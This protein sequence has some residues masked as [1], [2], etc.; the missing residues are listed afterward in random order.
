MP[1]IHLIELDAYHLASGHTHRWFLATKPGYRSGP[2]DTPKSLPWLP[3]VGKPSDV[4]LSIASLG[5]TMGATRVTLGSVELDN[6]RDWQGERQARVYDVTADAWITVTL[7]VRPLNPLLTDYALAGWPLTEKVIEE[8]APYSTAQVVASVT[9]EMPDPDSKRSTINLA[10][11]GREA[12]FDDP[13]LTDKYTTSDGESLADRTKERLFGHAFQE[14]TYLGIIGGL[15][16]WSHNGG[17]PIED[18]PV[19]WDRAFRLTKRTTGTPA[20]GEFKTDPATGITVTGSRPPEPMCEVKGDKT[21][22][23]WR[24]Y[25]GELAQHLAVTVGGKVPLARMDAVSV[26]TLDAVPREVGYAIPTGSSPTLREALDKLLGSLARGYWIVTAE[27]LLTVGRL[28]APAAPAARVYRRGINTPGLT[29]RNTNDRGLPAK[30]VTLRY[31]GLPK[32][33]QTIVT[34]AT[35]ADTQLHKALWRE[36]TDT[37]AATAAAYPGARSPT[38]ETLLWDRT[39]AV[40][41]Q[42]EF[43]AELKQVRRVYDLVAQDGAP[44][45][46]RRAVLQVFD[47]LAGYEAGRLVTVIG[48]INNARS[49]IPTLVVRE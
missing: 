43:L 17:H 38:V 44:G 35:E 10:V 26:T 46:D 12:D 9:M 49:K 11:R 45:I 37:D 30:T 4:S 32:V 5:E 36:V 42:A 40:A 23:V 34:E 20:A 8:G 21:G 22:G 33:T 28:L 6:A 16:H 41:E 2:G 13:L 29:P 27:D 31:A 3:L 7:P 1:T 14:P 48:R 18:V 25:V 19:F 24:R 47:D 39:Q 15:H